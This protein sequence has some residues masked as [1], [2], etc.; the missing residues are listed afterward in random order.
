VSTGRWEKSDE[1][2]FS[3]HDGASGLLAI[4]GYQNR[5]KLLK[6]LGDLGKPGPAGQGG[7]GGLLDQL[8]KN[9]RETT[10][11]RVLI[12]GLGELVD[13]FKQSGYG[14]TAD[15][16]VGTGPNKSM[17]P[18]QLEQA[19]GPEVLDNLSKQTGLSK[20][21]LLGRLSRS[22]PNT[23]DSYTPEGRLPTQ[24]TPAA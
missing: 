12:D 6:M 5:D 8:R 15:S 23:V 1:S 21:D 17:T 24:V 20:D 18:A 9:L 13:R 7:I 11:G 4:A 3:I 22:L 10:P 14:D 2:R 16:W 19:I